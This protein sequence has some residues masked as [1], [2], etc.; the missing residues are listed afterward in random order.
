MRWF[1]AGVNVFDER[2]PLQPTLQNAIEAGVDRL[3]VIGTSEQD[4]AAC[5]DAVEQ[6]AEHLCCTFGV[7]PHYA[8]HVSAD[9]RSSLA[10]YLREFPAAAVGECGLD[11]NRMFSSKKNQLD[12]FETQLGLASEFGLPVYLH[13]RDAFE[14]QYQI[15]TDYRPELSGGLVHCFTSHTAHLKDYL[16][17]DLYIGITGWL[18]EPKRGHD[19]REAIQYL[20][21]DRLILET[22]APYLFPKGLKPRQRN[23]APEN[24]PFIAT[25][26]AQIKGISV[27]E[28]SQVSII[29][30]NTLLWPQHD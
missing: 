25:Q 27:E 14:D 29:N 2:L 6:H 30:T 18:C 11:F 17:L 7:H 13:E 26:V 24:L 3:C 9:W 15:L 28:V 19:L 8:D 5:A 20:P 16:E 10:N 23:N 22:D 4:W 21:L 1:D 12:V